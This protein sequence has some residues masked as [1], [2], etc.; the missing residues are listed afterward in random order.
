[1]S[2]NPQNIKNNFYQEKTSFKVILT[3]ENKLKA[4]ENQLQC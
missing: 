4:I 2:T 3:I 1:M